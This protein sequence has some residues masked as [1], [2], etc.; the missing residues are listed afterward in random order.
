MGEAER[1]AAAPVLRWAGDGAIVIEYGEVISSELARR[2]QRV[3]AALEAAGLP[4]LVEAVPTYR[5]TLAVIRPE[6]VWPA[7]AMQAVERI[8][9][10]AESEGDANVERRVVEVP[11]YYG[12]EYGPDLG[13]VAAHAGLSPEEVIAIHIAPTYEVQMIGFML[14]FPYLA[15]MDPRIATP[16]L[17]TPRTLIPAGSVGIAG[18]QPGVYPLASPGGW[19]I[20]GRT[21]LRLADPS[22]DPPC[23]LRA[24]DMVKFVPTEPPQ[25]SKTP[26]E[27]V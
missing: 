14:G 6:E 19:R 11:V 26:P 1:T 2:A 9:A 27:V 13:D 23:L 21:P 10:A 22:S 8:V 24:G 4:W 20:I 3:A 15:G 25:E 5:S 16:R 12:G 7:E 17:T 18:N